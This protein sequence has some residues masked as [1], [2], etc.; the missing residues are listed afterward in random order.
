MLEIKHQ[1]RPR[2]N[3]KR[4]QRKHM[5]AYQCIWMTFNTLPNVY[6]PNHMASVRIIATI[7]AVDA[8]ESRVIVKHGLAGLGHG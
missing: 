5:S 8:A 3:Y 6:Y 4:D 2:K 7:I 1:T